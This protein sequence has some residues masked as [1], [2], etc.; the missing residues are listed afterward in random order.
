MEAS[1]KRLDTDYLDIYFIHH[2][3]DT[4]PIE[5]TLHTLDDLV[6]AGKILYPAA[7]NFAVAVRNNTVPQTMAGYFLP[8][9]LSRCCVWFT[10]KLESPVNDARHG[11]KGG[12]DTTKPSLFG[13][14]RPTEYL[15]NHRIL[16]AGT[17]KRRQLI[18]QTLSQIKQGHELVS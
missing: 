9:G 12:E 3:D 17:A 18:T 15:P 5:E 16:R 11:A 14:C 13:L 8:A 7:S 4:T 2:F 6:R 1:L 10:F